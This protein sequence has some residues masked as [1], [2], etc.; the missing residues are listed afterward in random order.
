MYNN[1]QKEKEK[2]RLILRD[3]A[4]TASSFISNV[5]KV[6]AVLN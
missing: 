5:G 6:L 1:Y 4:S 2:Y 3:Y